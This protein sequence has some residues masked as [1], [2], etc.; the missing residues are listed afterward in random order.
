MS[1]LVIGYGRVT[2]A[3]PERSFAVILS[4]GRIVDKAGI[5]SQETESRPPT[6]STYTSLV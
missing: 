6:S 1:F 5:V 3:D 2:A 4:H